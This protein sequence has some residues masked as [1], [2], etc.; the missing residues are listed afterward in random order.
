MATEN[1]GIALG[2]A[3]KCDWVL[4]LEDDVTPCREFLPS[5]MRWIERHARETARL[6]SFYLTPRMAAGAL[7]SPGVRAFPV[8]SFQ[9]AQAFAL[10]WDDAQACSQ[11]IAAHAPTW[12]VGPAWPGWAHKRGSDRMVA[13]WHQAAYAEIADGIASDPCFVEHEGQ[14][15]SLRAIKAFRFHRAAVFTGEPWL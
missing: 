13:A 14:V 10:R 8:P 6:V 11:W 3:P 1:M 4:H 7:R 15:S 9:A 5:V 2:A 12:R